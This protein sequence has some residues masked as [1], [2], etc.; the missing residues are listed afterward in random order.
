M[1]DCNQIK[2]G[3][4]VVSNTEVSS[5]PLDNSGGFSGPIMKGSVENDK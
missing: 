5:L 4:N 1:N 2:K 3:M